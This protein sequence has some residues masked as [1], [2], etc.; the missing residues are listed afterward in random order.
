MFDEELRVRL[1]CGRTKMDED[2][3]LSDA[4]DLEVL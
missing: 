4:R 2:A 1:S 3:V